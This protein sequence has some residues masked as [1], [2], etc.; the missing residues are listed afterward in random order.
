VRRLVDE[1][2]AAFGGAFRA[3]SVLL[4]M[5][6]VLHGILVY[7]GIVNPDGLNLGVGNSISLIV[8]LTVAIY[9]LGGIAYPGLAT[10]QGFWA[11]I[12][13]LA[14]AAQWALPS[15]AV[16]QYGGDTV[17]ALHFAIAMLA[18]A[19]FAV[20]S[21]H[22]VVMLAEE[23]WL[24]RGVMPPFL[25]GLPPL[26]EMEALLFRIVMAARAAHAHVVSGSSSPAAGRPQGHHKT[27]FG[28]SVGIFGSSSGPVLGWRGRAVPTLGVCAAARLPRQQ[29]RPRDHPAPGLIAGPGVRPH[30][31]RLALHGPRR[32]APHRRVLLDRRDE[33]DGAQPL[34]PEAPGAPGKR[35][36]KL[37]QDLLDQP[38]SCSA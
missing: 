36:A 27:V 29:V 10:L 12:A 35:S 38:T 24:R 5:A 30:T 32:D 33:H 25:R 34:S 18:Y 9:W 19:L 37:T 23:R 15:R 1:T 2:V 21:V 13:A 14:V 17:F 3:E 31:A 7:R 22:A 6:L 28:L 8:W 16:V 11:P 20:A 4:A 26:L